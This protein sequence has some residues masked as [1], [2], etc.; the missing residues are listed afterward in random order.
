MEIQRTRPTHL[1]LKNKKN[2][3]PLFPKILITWAS[4]SPALFLNVEDSQRFLDNYFVKKHQMIC[5]KDWWSNIRLCYWIFLLSRKLFY[6]LHL[7]FT[8]WSASLVST[9]LIF[10]IFTTRKTS[11]LDMLR[12]T[13]GSLQLYSK[14]LIF[15]SK[16]SII[17]SLYTVVMLIYVVRY[18]SILM[19][20]YLNRNFVAIFQ[21]FASWINFFLFDFFGMEVVINFVFV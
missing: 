17:F 4:S 1:C 13:F 8:L 20:K 2:S 11:F 6:H 15:F 7:M 16:S 12:N 10:E 3:L 18:L 14:R 21:R 19:Y 5:S 9:F